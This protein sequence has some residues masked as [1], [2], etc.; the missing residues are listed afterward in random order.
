MYV[1]VCVGVYVYIFYMCVCRCMYIYIYMCVCVLVK[2]T[3]Y[4][5]PARL[6]NL[7]GDVWIRPV[8]CDSFSNWK[9]DMST[10][11]FKQMFHV[12]HFNS[13]SINSFASCAQDILLWHS[14]NQQYFQLAVASRSHVQTR[15]WFFDSF[16]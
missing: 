4:V 1:Y 13:F 16:F 12:N 15:D 8:S 6:M 10:I 9:T 3:A 5:L 11:F 14:H 7:E 2:C